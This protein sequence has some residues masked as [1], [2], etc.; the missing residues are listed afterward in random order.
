MAAAD[1]SDRESPRREL[2]TSDVA[3]TRTAAM[4]PPRTRARGRPHATPTRT[5][6]RRALIGRKQTGAK[7]W[8]AKLIM[9]SISTLRLADARVSSDT[10]KLAGRFRAPRFGSASR[11]SRWLHRALATDPRKYKSGDSCHSRRRSAHDK[12]G[13][14]PSAVISHIHILNTS[15]APVCR[16]VDSHLHLR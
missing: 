16:V 11:R 5:S 7:S 14:S 9:E 4:T 6:A 1:H 15:A 13:N 3:S 12:S 2:V 8:R 10:R